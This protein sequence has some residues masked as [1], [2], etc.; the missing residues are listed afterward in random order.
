MRTVNDFMTALTDYFGPFSNKT[1]ALDIATEA[2]YI[3]PADLDKLLRQIKITIPASWTPDLKSVIEAIKAANIETMMLPGI[4]KE[5]PV[6][7][8][9]WKTTGVCPNCAYAG[10]ADGTPE[11]YR[12]W[13]QAWKE[14]K[15]PHYDVA[16][17]L[18]ELAESK[19]FPK[20]QQ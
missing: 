16:K 15:V 1:V 14:G 6:C 12:Q 9:H 13:W 7:G 8:N 20:T 5:C 3:K 2:G 19:A 17:T 18:L 4:Q 11:E 10:K